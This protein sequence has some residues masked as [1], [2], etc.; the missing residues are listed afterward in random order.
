MCVAQRSKLIYMY[1]SITY[2]LMKFGRMTYD[3]SYHRMFNNNV[4]TMSF[5]T[6][7]KVISSCVHE[8]S[9]VLN[10]NVHKRTKN[11]EFNII[12]LVCLI[13]SEIIT[14]YSAI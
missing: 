4:K 5:D 11:K 13:Y 10:S 12:E 9:F 14:I 6:F 8:S 7:E 3:G 1:Q 2:W